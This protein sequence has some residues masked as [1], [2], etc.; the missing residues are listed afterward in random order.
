MSSTNKTLIKRLAARMFTKHRLTNTVHRLRK[1]NKP[2][3]Y[4]E[5]TESN[6]KQVFQLPDKYL[7]DSSCF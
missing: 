5:S 2:S 7:T 3:F 4:Q 1:V 6:N